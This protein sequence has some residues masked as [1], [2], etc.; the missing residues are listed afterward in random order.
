MEVNHIELN[1]GLTV[2]EVVLQAEDS[3]ELIQTTKASDK[4]PVIR[5]KAVSYEQAYPNEEGLVRVNGSIN[6]FAVIGRV[7]GL[8]QIIVQ[9]LDMPYSTPK[10]FK[11]FAEGYLKARLSPTAWNGQGIGLADYE[12]GEK[13]GL[14][15][16]ARKTGYFDFM[17]SN[18]AMDI[19]LR[20]FDPAFGEEETLRDYETQ[21]GKIKHPRDS[22]MANRV[23]IAYMVLLN[24]GRELLLVKKGKGL[25]I[26]GGTLCLPGSTP[27]WDEDTANAIRN[28]VAKELSD[29]LTLSQ[30]EYDTGKAW[31]VRDL[32][33][34]QPA[35]F[36]TVNVNPK[37]NFE[38]IA[39]ACLASPEARREHTRLYKV[40]LAGMQRT[41]EAINAL[42]SLRQYNVH[43]STPAAVSFLI[44]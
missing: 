32:A 12:F 41:V 13:G 44:T 11:K 18:L 9:A 39:E 42:S 17:W 15:L 36:V 3:P 21:N 22:V 37:R 16:A 31:F 30:P 10:L 35:F 28:D 29:E 23:G 1:N 6:P 14:T 2:D 34:G 33:N 8:E 38:D 7:D 5:R 4:A 19:H 26:A 27:G 40:P 25:A 43:H 20:Q 24:N